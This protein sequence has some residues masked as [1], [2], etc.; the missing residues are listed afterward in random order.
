MKRILL[1]ALPFALMTACSNPPAAKDATDTAAPAATAAAAA[2]AATTASIDASQPSP[3][4]P[5]AT[6]SVSSPFR[7][8]N[9]STRTMKIARQPATAAMP[10]PIV[11]AST[12]WQLEEAVSAAGLALSVDEVKA[13]ESAYRPHPV[14][15]HT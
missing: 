7:K 10:A 11:G 5:A 12:V 15:G 1:L 14:L 13:L 4:A 3:Y 9:P 8:A 6:R 2:P